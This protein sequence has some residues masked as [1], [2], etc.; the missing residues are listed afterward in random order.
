MPGWGVHT[1][2][3][4]MVVSG[5]CSG[6]DGEGGSGADPVSANQGELEF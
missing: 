5:G 3:A 6:P 1:V 4:K 2:G